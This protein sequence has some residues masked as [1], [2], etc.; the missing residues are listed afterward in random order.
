MIVIIGAGLT[1]L[2]VA[3]HLKNGSYRIFEKEDAPGGLCRSITVDGFT[4]DYTGHLL[5]CKHASTRR[6]LSRVLKGGLTEVT[7]KAAIYC[8]GTFLPYPFQANLFGLPK[9]VIYECVF[10][11]LEK[12]LE[13]K[14][15]RKNSTF[16]DWI[17]HAFGEGMARHFF[18]PYNEKL[19]RT[20]LR[21]LTSDWASWSVP[22]PTLEEVVRGALGITNTGMGYNASFLYPSKGGIGLLPDALSA[23]LKNL[24]TGTELVGLN[25]K[26][27]KLFFS[28]GKELTY[29][30]LVSTIPLP[31][32]L[33]KI[34]DLPKTYTQAAPKLSFVSVQN[35]N[36]GVNRKNVSDYHWIY[37]PEPEFP[38]YRVGFYSNFSDKVAPKNTSSLYVEISTTRRK[39]KDFAAL[40]EQAVGALQRCGI[41]KKGDRIIVSNYQDID[42]AY[43][44]YDRFRQHTLPGVERYL[45][46]HGIISAGRYGAWQYSAMEDSLVA[47]REIAG[48]IG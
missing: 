18:I 28:D 43:V 35:L 32:L 44:I 15:L 5:H 16:K 29:D 2:S 46:R 47:G 37:F 33:T 1:G 30:R 39:K 4:F 34:E 23:S 31:E 17:T 10:G 21:N 40:Q 45:N 24:Q 41:L 19:W 20:D 42:Y 22:R 26:K 7:R 48:L 36:I 25:A 14:P 38:F 3:R 9:E 8:R 11:F 6:M 13:K 27:K 12:Q